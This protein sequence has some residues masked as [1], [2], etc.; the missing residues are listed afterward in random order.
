VET[1]RRSSAITYIAGADDALQKA[2][3]GYHMRKYTYAE[4]VRTKDNVTINA[5]R[6]ATL[7]GRP[8][9]REK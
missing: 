3:Y 2:D 5:I 9:G 7:T 6:K 8:F 4:F 1:Y